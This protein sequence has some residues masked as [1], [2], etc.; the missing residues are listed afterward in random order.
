VE[1]FQ[2]SPAVP[3]GLAVM[4]QAYYLLEMQELA[5]NAVAVMAANYPEHPSLTADGSFDYDQRLIE[6]G[7]SF[8]AKITFGLIERVESA[9]I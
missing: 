1:N 4:A 8:L 3:D 6:S 9:S 2:Q 7:D 5:D